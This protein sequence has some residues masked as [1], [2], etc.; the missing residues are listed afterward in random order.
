M[1]RTSNESAKH[2]LA[3]APF[4]YRGLDSRTIEALVA[5]GIDASE[6]LLF[7]LDRELLSIPGVGRASLAKIAAYRDRFGGTRGAAP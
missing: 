3:M 4:W 5:A 6:R 2:D 7:M 1:A